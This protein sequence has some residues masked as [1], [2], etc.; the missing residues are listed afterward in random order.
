MAFRLL[1]CKHF[2]S[3]WGAIA[4]GFSSGSKVKMRFWANCNF[5]IWE[6]STLGVK[7]VARKHEYSSRKVYNWNICH[8]NAFL[9]AFLLDCPIPNMAGS[10]HFP[11]SSE[12]QARPVAYAVSCL[13]DVFLLFTGNV[14][15]VLVWNIYSF[16]SRKKLNTVRA[17][18]SAYFVLYR[19]VK[20][21]RQVMYLISCHHN[22]FPLS[23]YHIKVHMAHPVIVLN[24]CMKF[25][26]Y[27]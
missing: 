15:K 14:D 16:M 12:P 11:V 23:I 6:F 19:S 2:G 20:F 26:Q 24:R 4:C 3:R 9:S 13:R 1:Y 21:S 10:I 25:V 22:S 7:W 17:H 5:S 8:S 18:R 27:S